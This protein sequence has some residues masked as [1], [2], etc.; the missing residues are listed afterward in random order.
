VAIRLS[1]PEG[2]ARHSMVTVGQPAPRSRP[3]GARIERAIALAGALEKWCQR[4]RS[5]RAPYSDNEVRI[6]GCLRTSAHQRDNLGGQADRC[7]SASP[8]LSSTSPRHRAISDAIAS[9]VDE[10]AKSITGGWK[11]AAL[12]HRRVSHGGGQQ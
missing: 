9:R 10:V 4:S 7:A 11:S 3:P 1:E 8:A 2:A 5:A 6:R 12:H